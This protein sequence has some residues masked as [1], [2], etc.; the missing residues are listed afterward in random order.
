MILDKGESVTKR[1]RKQY[2]LIIQVNSKKLPLSIDIQSQ[3]NQSNVKI[4]CIENYENP[5]LK[6]LEGLALGFTKLKSIGGWVGI[7]FSQARPIYQS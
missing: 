1:H 7:R 3:R 2:N 4:V 6:N 5:I